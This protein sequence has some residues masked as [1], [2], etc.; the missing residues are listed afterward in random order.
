MP[1]VLGALIATVTTSS[2]GMM[3]ESSH[4]PAGTANQ[5]FLLLG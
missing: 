2:S 5:V 1:A 4:S 3:A